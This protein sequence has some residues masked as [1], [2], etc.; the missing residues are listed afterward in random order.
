MERLCERYNF[1]S[2]DLVLDVS[3]CD[4]GEESASGILLV[5]LLSLEE[6]DDVIGLDWSEFEAINGRNG[7]EICWSY[8]DVRGIVGLSSR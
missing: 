5:G 8:N 4:V 6:E 2:I 7:I 1:H 3:G